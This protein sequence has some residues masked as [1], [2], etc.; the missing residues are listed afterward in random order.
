[1][2]DVFQI[3]T[4]TL[5]GV[6]YI[7]YLTKA[8]MLKRRGITVNQLGK[9]DKPKGALIIELFL[10]VATLVGAVIQ[11]SS[12]LFPKDVWTLALPSAVQIAGLVLIV[13]GVLFFVIAMFTMRD[14]WRAGFVNN[15]NTSLVTSGIYRISRNPAFV[16]FD[17]L[18]I[19]CAAVFPN[20]LN[21]AIALMAVVLFH[22]QILGEEKYCAES[23]GEQ[24]MIYKSKTMRY[25][26]F[27]AS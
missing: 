4:L 7:A 23:F 16:G 25:L 6:F 5:L 24:Y 13:V 11:F 26:G 20:I 21:I 17:L 1:M 22:F 8:L 19:G 10:R 12:A 9:G 3:L 18:Y 27:K 15:Q 2:M 14:N